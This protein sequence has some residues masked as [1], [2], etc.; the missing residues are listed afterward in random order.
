MTDNTIAAHVDAAMAKISAATLGTEQQPGE[1][2][3]PAP[4]AETQ[5]EPHASEAPAEPAASSEQKPSSVRGPD[6][7]FAKAPERVKLPSG[8]EYSLAE[9]EA[10]AAGHKASEVL[11]AKLDEQSTGVRQ[12][13]ENAQKLAEQA[14][15]ERAETERQRVAIQQ[16]LYAQEQ[17][18]GPLD[19]REHLRPAFQK[20]QQT[21]DVELTEE[22]LDRRVEQRVSKI[23][24]QQSLKSREQY[25]N[26]NFDEWVKTTV[27]SDPHL[28]P[29]SEQYGWYVT[30][31][32]RKALA[33]RGMSAHDMRDS[34]LKALIKGAVAEASL[35]EEKL[36][37]QDV[38]S[39]L[40]TH[41]RANKALPAVPL[42][43]GTALPQQP[44]S[45]KFDVRK[46][47]AE[48][49]SLDEAFD[50]MADQVKS[51][52]DEIDRLSKEIG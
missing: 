27:E 6:G 40:D 28:K 32:I 3:S 48:S 2:A 12:M 17:N 30:G 36:R 5:A 10:I 42:N 51:K 1:P 47:F 37:A 41:A 18:G 33:E 24:Q 19:I 39:T 31:Q 38:G 20:N 11:K 7:K 44:Q 52:F 23:L 35:R 34:D 9:L 49:R 43:A 15:A 45:M 16:A 46:T 21:G 8:D 29:R 4:V 50:R 22:E 26:E 25:L 13:Y 14:K